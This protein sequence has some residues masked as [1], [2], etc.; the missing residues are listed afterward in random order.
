MCP[1]ENENPGGAGYRT[2]LPGTVHVV[3]HNRPGCLR[4]GQY[5]LGRG[6]KCPRTGQNVY[7]DRTLSRKWTRAH[8]YTIASKMPSWLWGGIWGI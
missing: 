4:M 3:S 2:R 7:R 1:D 8:P 5:C 6:Q